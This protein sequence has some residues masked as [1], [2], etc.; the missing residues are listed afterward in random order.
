MGI[1]AA[2]LF[3]AAL[4]LPCLWAAWSDLT[5]MTIPNR[6][7]LAVAAIYVVLG[8]LV[9]PFD[10]YLWGFAN[11]AIALV[12][13]FLLFLTGQFGAGDAKFLAAIALYVGRI[14]VPTVLWIYAILALLSVAVVS[15][16]KWR[17]KE[18][19]AKGPLGSLR[20]KRRFPLGLPLA[21]SILVYLAL[22]VRH[23]LILS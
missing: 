4:A 9:L 21:L 11:G 13:G 15:L 8:P 20:E 12:A 23:H 14:D 1:E 17:M 2:A 5:T 22:V 16:V 3:L 6:I 18:F 19:A 7:V 10:A